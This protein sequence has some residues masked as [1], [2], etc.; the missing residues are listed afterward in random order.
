MLLT[1]T[2]DSINY[3]GSQKTKYSSLKN[4]INN[5]RSILLIFKLS[6][7]FLFLYFYINNQLK[8]SYLT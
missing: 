6:Y 5:L 3:K 8:Y 2:Y 1:K 7:I 4:G